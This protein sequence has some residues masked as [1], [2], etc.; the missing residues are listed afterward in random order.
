M[1]KYS[2][3]FKM[4]VVAEYLSDTIGYKPLAKKYNMKDTQQI[5]RWVNAYQTSGIKGLKRSRQNK[6]Y[7]VEFKL[8][9]ITLYESG[10]KSYQTLANELGINNPS[11]I[12]TWRSIYLSQGIKGL[13]RPKGRPPIMSLSKPN[14]RQTKQDPPELT[15]LEQANQ[16]IK[17]LE[18][19]LELQKIKNEYLEQL[20]S[21]R[22]Q[23]AMKTKQESSTNSV[24]KDIP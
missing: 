7:S 24:T 20:R 18:Y 13:S 2:L 17:E 19:E 11:L 4:K 22:R 23:K 12:A 5:R 8:K 14:K 21:L 6:K 16:R 10:E 9:A 1:A 15:D 3:E